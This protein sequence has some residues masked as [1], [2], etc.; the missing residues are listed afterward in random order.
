MHRFVE[1]PPETTRWIERLQHYPRIVLSLLVLAFLVPFAGKAFHMDDPLFIW[2]AEHIRAEPLNP[3]GFDVN[4]YGTAMPMA[5]VTKNPPLA[6]YYIA[7]VSAV[8][9]ASEMS[10]HLAFIAPALAAVLGIF[11][12]AQRLC[13][14]AFFAALA[15]LS[16][17]VFLVSSTTV[18]SDVLM[19]AFWIWAIVLWIDGLER[20]RAR[21]FSSALS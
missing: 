4:W 17:P 21:L 3:Y 14:S 7:T 9:G 5:D 12:L 1:K 18:M 11:A 10:L 15:A 13:R 6:S 19:L 2:A 20:H 8:F 16:C